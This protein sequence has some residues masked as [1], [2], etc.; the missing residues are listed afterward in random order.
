MLNQ[1]A[2]GRGFYITWNDLIYIQLAFIL[3]F[4]DV[5]VN[6]IYDLT[7]GIQDTDGI[8]PNLN[9]IR[10]GIPF[11]GEMF[12]RRIPMSE[13]PQDDEGSA[14]FIH[15]LYREKVKCFA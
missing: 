2:A 7:I 12:V 8:K 4:F 9:A 5:L 15:K 11:K 14:Q 1:G 6:A 10:N 3:C 13:V